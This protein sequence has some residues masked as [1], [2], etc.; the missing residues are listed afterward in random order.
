MT[1]PYTPKEIDVFS[2]VQAASVRTG[3]P[4][5]IAVFRHLMNYTPFAVNKNKL[6]KDIR[7]D[8]GLE[9]AGFAIKD[10]AIIVRTIKN[11]EDKQFLEEIGGGEI[12]LTGTGQEAV[13]ILRL[14]KTKK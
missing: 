1:T 11:L 5:V 2:D 9:K 3:L 10:D 14:N 13:E 7:E 8:S 4:L 6:L 12:R